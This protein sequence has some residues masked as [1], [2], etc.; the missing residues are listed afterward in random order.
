[1]ASIQ[2]LITAG[3]PVVVIL[4]GFS[5]VALTVI[6]L[7]LWQFWSLGDNGGKYIEEALRH[8]EQ[9]DRAQ[10]LLLAGD[11]RNPRADVVARGLRL[12]DKPWLTVDDIRDEITRVARGHLN[13]LGSLLR[14]LEVIAVLAPL[15]GL[16]GTVLGMIDAFKAMAAAGNQVNPATLSEGIWVALLTT[17]VGLAV[18]MPTSLFNSAFDRHVENI[19]ARMTDDIGR[20]LTAQAERRGVEARRHGLAQKA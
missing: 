2:S 1:M 4:L 18:A 7:K 11:H 12:L 3:G 13:G 16:F 17:A 8:L 10:A 15:L 14:I 9:G 19:A 20:I 6:A 5:M